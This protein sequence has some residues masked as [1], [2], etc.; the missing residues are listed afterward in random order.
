MLVLAIYTL[1]G[2]LSFEFW[3]C[4]FKTK[5]FDNDPIIRMFFSFGGGILWASAFI[6]IK[7]NE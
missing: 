5:W 1:M 7:S 4:I 6:I 3:Q 2:F